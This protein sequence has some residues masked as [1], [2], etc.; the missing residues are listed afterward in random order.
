[1]KEMMLTL[2]DDWKDVVKLI[3]DVETEKTLTID[4]SYNHE[5]QKLK[6]IALEMQQVYFINSNFA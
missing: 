3:Q 4:S 2:Q 6:N 5:L 1:M